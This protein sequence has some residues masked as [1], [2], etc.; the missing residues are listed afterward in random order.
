MMLALSEAALLPVRPETSQGT[1]EQRHRT[2]G[3]DRDGVPG[4]ARALSHPCGL[5]LYVQT[6]S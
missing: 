2:A 4:Q 1:E 3:S 6:L 5:V